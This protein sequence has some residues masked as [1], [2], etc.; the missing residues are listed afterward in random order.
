MSKLAEFQAKQG[1]HRLEVLVHKLADCYYC[2]GGS[3]E[4]SKISIELHDLLRE[5]EAALQEDR[6]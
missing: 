5:L 1:A 3:A 6:R 2:H 4:W